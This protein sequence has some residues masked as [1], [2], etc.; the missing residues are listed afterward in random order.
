MEEDKLSLPWL[1]SPWRRWQWPSCS[2]TSPW[3]YWTCSHLLLHF[4]LDFHPRQHRTFTHY[5]RSRKCLFHLFHGKLVQWI[6]SATGSCH[7][8]LHKIAQVLESLSPRQSM[9]NVWRIQQTCTCIATKK[10]CVRNQNECVNIHDDSTRYTL[11]YNHHLRHKNGIH[12]IVDKAYKA[13]V[14]HRLKS[15]TI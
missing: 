13:F 4:H 14:K 5:N 6:G 9:I 10:M 8:V 15:I 7:V 12:S 1:R 2:T 3:W 11:T